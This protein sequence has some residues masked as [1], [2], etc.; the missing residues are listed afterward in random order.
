MKYVTRPWVYTLR[1]SMVDVAAVMT[2]WTKVT[3][4]PMLGARTLVASLA[5]EMVSTYWPLNGEPK[6]KEPLPPLMVRLRCTSG[7]ES[8]PFHSML[9]LNESAAVDSAGTPVMDSPSHLAALKAT[10][11]DSVGDV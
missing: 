3:A 1:C 6:P 10:V 5:S 9:M 2:S 11:N 4:Y 8:Y 7:L